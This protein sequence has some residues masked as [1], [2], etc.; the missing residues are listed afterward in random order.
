MH[1]QTGK[2]CSKV[3]EAIVVCCGDWRRMGR[4]KHSAWSNTMTPSNVVRSILKNEEVP[5]QHIGLS[6]YKECQIY[7][8]RDLCDKSLS[9]G[10]ELVARMCC[11]VWHFATVWFFLP[12]RPPLWQKLVTRKSTVRCKLLIAVWIWFENL[13]RKLCGHSFSVQWQ[14]SWWSFTMFYEHSSSGVWLIN[15]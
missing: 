13:Q 4:L 9:H 12:Y 14:S 15:C 5:R 2:W 7:L 8:G 11:H 1:L 6:L 10:Q 3:C